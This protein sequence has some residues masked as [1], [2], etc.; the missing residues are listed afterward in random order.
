MR[1]KIKAGIVGGAGY[2]GG[3]TLRLLLL[4]P[5]VEVVFVHSKSQS[6]KP[7]I[8]VH[9]D[10]LGL[11][12]LSFVNKINNNIDV[13]FLCLGHGESKMFLQSTKIPASV[14]II[15]LSQDFRHTQ[16]AVFGKRKFIYGLP[17]L[18]RKAIQKAENIANPGCF[19]TCIQLALLPLAAND[20]LQ[21]EVHVSATTGSTGAGQSLSETSHFSWRQNNLEPY[22]IF[23]HQHLTE[24]TESLSQLQPQKPRINFVPYRGAFTRGILAT[25]YLDTQLTEKQLTDIFKSYYKNHPFVQIAPFDVNLKQV[26]NTNNCFLQ[27]SKKNGKAVIISVLDNLLKGASGQAVQNMNLMFGI[28]EITGLKLKPS[29]F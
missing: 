24:I 14:R 8:S 4:H 17:E 19:A 7:V 15:D 21:P 23:E 5:Q 28:D 11:T 6:G 13:L 2:T 3:E 18:N 29:A 16:N 12:D 10:C 20:Q 25:T 22:K 9:H 27:V 26:V 1:N